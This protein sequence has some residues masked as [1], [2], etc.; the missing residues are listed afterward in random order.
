MKELKYKKWDCVVKKSRYQNNNNLAL[1]LIDKNDGSC[2]ANITINTD[3]I[4]LEPDL[5]YVKNYSEGE[6]MLEALQEAGLIEEII[7]TKKVGWVKAPLVRF[8]L[9]DVED[10]NS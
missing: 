8:N 5:A 6:G 7:K 3:E 4:L 10:I 9:A 2:V 1:I